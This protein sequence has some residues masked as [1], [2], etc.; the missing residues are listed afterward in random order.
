MNFRENNF[1][2][3]SPKGSLSLCVAHFIL[4]LTHVSTTYNRSQTIILIVVACNKRGQERDLEKI[5]LKV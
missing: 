4:S 1:L 2:K 5:T 3:F